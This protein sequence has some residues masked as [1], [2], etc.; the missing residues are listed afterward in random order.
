MHALPLST[1]VSFVKK[2]CSDCNHRILVY[3][4]T[5]TPMEITLNHK[6]IMATIPG[7]CAITIL[8]L[9]SICILILTY[10]QQIIL[11]PLRLEH[12]MF[13]LRLMHLGTACHLM[14]LRD[15]LDPKDY[16]F[17][18]RLIPYWVHY[19]VVLLEGIRK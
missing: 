10:I 1:V 17:F 18:N 15:L 19:M 3:T 4:F 9:C 5:I 16:G 8:Q 12:K 2:K 14:C 11:V 7:V 13:P 6:V